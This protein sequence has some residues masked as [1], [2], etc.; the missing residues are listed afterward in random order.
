MNRLRLLLGIG[1][2]GVVGGGLS[3]W[4]GFRHQM[5]TAAGDVQNQCGPNI[6]F[7]IPGIILV[8][9]GIGLL[10]MAYQHDSSSRSSNVDG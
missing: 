5:C 9:I 3:I 8:L 10:L 4:Y 1:T 7:L 2:F 6:L